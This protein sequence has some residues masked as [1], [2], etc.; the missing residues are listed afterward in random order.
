MCHT[1]LKAFL[2]VALLLAVVALLLLV[3]GPRVLPYRVDVVAS[4]SME[5]T[6]AKG[7]I[8]V[9]R[10]ITADKV[11]VGDII[12]FYPPDH[13]DL[14]T[15][16]V[17]DIKDGADGPVF[18]TQGDANPLPDPWQLPVTGS[19]WHLVAHYPYIGYL[20]S[21]GGIS[22]GPLSLVDVPILALALSLLIPLWMPHRLPRKSRSEP[23][24]PSQAEGN[25]V[26]E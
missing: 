22:F 25:L 2:A 11:K 20:M 9:L 14:V 5:P 3:V 17:V 10:P 19:G 7:S 1:L 26:E 24:E 4:G 12:T 21:V 18:V 23:S 15:H 8:V 13:H 16:R 6:I